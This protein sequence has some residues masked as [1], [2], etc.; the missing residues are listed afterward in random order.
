MSLVLTKF[1]VLKSHPLCKKQAW[2]QSAR[3][4]MLYYPK[5]STKDTK[6]SSSLKI[7]SSIFTN[8]RFISVYFSQYILCRLRCKLSDKRNTGN[9][10][11]SFCGS[12]DC[13]ALKHK[14]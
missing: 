9:L 7:Q 6:K 4:D 2:L 11:V 10:L 13:S 5:I 3:I 1:L 8:K 12:G 14:D